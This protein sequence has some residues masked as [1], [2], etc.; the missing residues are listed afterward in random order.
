LKRN[1]IFSQS[2]PVPVILGGGPNGLGLVR[3]LGQSGIQSFLLDTSKSYSFYS[4]YCYGLV[5]PNPTSNSDIFIEFL[6]NFGKK[7]KNKGMLFT[8]N[9]MW[10]IPVSQNRKKLEEHFVFSM[11]DWFVIDACSNKKKMYSIAEEH[12][13]P[14]P[15]TYYLN[16]TNELDIYCDKIPYPCILK[17]SVTIG[18]LEK[19]GSPGR[20]LHCKNK[21]E[22]YS[23]KLR[24]ENAGLKNTEMVL[25]EFIEGGAENLYTIT[26]YSNK[27]AKIIA[28][29][30]GHKIRQRPPDAGTIISGRV[31]PRPELYPQAQKLISAFGFFGIANTEFKFDRKD[32]NY[33]LMEINPRPGKWNYSAM[34]SGINMPKMI[35]DELTGN[36]QQFF[37]TTKEELVWG[38][39]AEDFYNAVLGGFKRKGYKDYSVSL[40]G[41][42]QSIRGRKVDAVFQNE[43]YLPGLMYVFYPVLKKLKLLK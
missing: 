7:L 31:I 21:E 26:S 24:I 22:L 28:Y 40:S 12:Q 16:N 37:G 39:F 9:D 42:F 30:T 19:L 11:S 20:V 3:S 38:V 36:A 13:I 29:S 8:T 25:Q 27:E 14:Y 18:F 41:Y 6:L 34:A 35:F 32:N 5:C 4:K 17:P 33:K 10:M 23:W 2:K 43:D 15:K 1:A